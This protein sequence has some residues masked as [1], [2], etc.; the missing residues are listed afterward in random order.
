MSPILRRF[1]ASLRLGFVLALAAAP[2]RAWQWTTTSGESVTVPA[3]G[4][5]RVAVAPDD[6]AALVEAMLAERIDQAGPAFAIAIMRHGELVYAGARGMADLERGVRADEHTVFDVASVAKSVTGAAIATLAEAGDVDLDASVRDHLPELSPAY[7]PVQLRHLVHHTGGVEDVQGLLALAGWRP[8]D[9]GTFED[10]LRVLRGVGHLRFEPGAMHVYS[11]GGYVLLAEVVR[12]VTGRGFPAWVAEHLF[13]PVGMGSAR[14]AEGDGALV[15]RRALPYAGRA[16]AL[17]LAR[18]TTRYGAGGLLVSMVDLVRWADALR[19]G[20]GIG[21]AVAKR[22]RERG[23][24]ADGS[25]LE[26]AFGLSRS[27]HDGREAWGHAGSAPGAQ[28]YLVFFPEEE[29]AIAAATNWIEGENPSRFAH[30]LAAVLLGPGGAAPPASS[31]P[32]MI[33]ISDAQERPDEA[34]GIQVDAERIAA[35]DGTYDMEDGLTILVG[36]EEDRLFIGFDSEPNI[37]LFPIDPGSSDVFLL[38]QPAWEFHF[39]PESDRLT[40]HVRESSRTGEPLD[41]A[42][43]RQVFEA[44]TEE[45]AR[46][47]VGVYESEELG[48]FYSVVWHEDA[49]WLEHARHGRLPLTLAAED[50]F[51]LP[52]RALARLDFVRAEAE[53]TGFRLEAYS[54]GAASFFAVR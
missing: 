9:A 42:G 39:E 27:F 12:R 19:S 36:S 21:A 2:A 15:A 11:N 29:L 7:D 34:T 28:S 41:I 52:G 30:E 25:E 47:L 16:G 6:A 23:R 43:E 45:T 46:E 35:F 10:A 40:I 22:V 32:R 3:D 31:G 5:A 20:E 44:L 17:R 8:P 48:A 24:L 26:Y 37:E 50:R 54:W 49:L 13:E 18:G 1:V 53:V 4:E 38:P 51:T 14:L 33:L